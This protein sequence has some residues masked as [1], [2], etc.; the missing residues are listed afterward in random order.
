VAVL[1]AALGGAAWYFGP[2]AADDPPGAQPAAARA[3]AWRSHPGLVE[4]KAP[5]PAD[6]NVPADPARRV[7][8][9]VLDEAGAPVPGADVQVFT[10]AQSAGPFFRCPAESVA[11][12]LFDAPC[13]EAGAALFA[14]VNESDSVEPVPLFAVRSGE[15]GEFAFDPPAEP[16]D[17]YVQLG[18]RY[19]TLTDLEATPE[20]GADSSADAGAGAGEQDPALDPGQPVQVER[21]RLELQL[22]E[23]PAVGGRVYSG[24]EAVPGADVLAVQQRPLRIWRT[25]ANAAGEFSFGRL[26][27]GPSLG[28]AAVAPGYLPLLQA[29]PTDE[30][31]ALELQR[32]GVVSGIVRSRGAPAAGARVSLDHGSQSAVADAEGRFSFPAVSCEICEVIGALGDRWAREEVGLDEHRKASLELDLQPVGE[33]QVHLVDRDTGAPLEGTLSCNCPASPEAP[34]TGLFVLPHAARGPLELVAQAEGHVPLR[35]TVE[36]G[37]GS[38]EV[39][40]ALDP[41]QRVEGRVLGPDGAPL[42]GALVSAFVDSE[43]GEETVATDEE[44]RF[45]LHGLGAGRHVVAATHPLH[46]REEV[47]VSL[48]AAGPLLLRLRLAARLLAEVVDPDGAPVPG[49][50]VFARLPQPNRMRSSIADEQ[51]RA[52]LS[53]LAPGSYLVSAAAGGWAGSEQVSVL[54]GAGESQVRLTLRR[55]LSIAGRVVDDAGAPVGRAEIYAVPQ[56]PAS[57]PL[58]ASATCDESGHFTL[59]GLEDAPYVLTPRREMDEGASSTVR[60]GAEAV[61]LRIDRPGEV[62]GRVTL[63]GQPLTT[64][65][66]VEGAPF[67]TEDGSFQLGLSPGEH[68]LTVAGSFAPRTFPVTV[69]AG[70]QVDVGEIAVGRGGVIEG[71]ALSPDG[72][73]AVGLDIVLTSG[74]SEERCPADH[75]GRFRFTDL[76]EGPYQLSAAGAQGFV[77]PVSVHLVEGQTLPTQLQAEAAGRL[78]GSV[79]DAAGSLVRF[80]R[81]ELRGPAEDTILMTVCDRRGEFAFDGLAPGPYRVIASGPASGLS[82]ERT[83]DVRGRGE[84]RAELRLPTLVAAETDLLEG[85]L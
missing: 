59:S 69:K 80:A 13:P 56:S 9:V 44:G 63:A 11:M 73:P 47:T 21:E 29:L 18:T 46:L 38:N 25:S 82:A 23:G 7:R 66:Y 55:G 54:A 85:E 14:L 77:R 4:A 41:E 27:G 19:A 26:P 76:A 8:G 60:P 22:S 50:S 16:F 39:V 33:L 74:G 79:T 48:P 49:A 67:E 81:V 51:G 12:P 15:K 62:V 28:A 35:K 5:R 31:A 6:P 70:Q 17:L 61:V 32:P 53:P 84:T 10:S 75:D 83:L 36:V 20:S 2:D 40:L 57:S 71:V 45:Q 78:A 68:E 1:A 58:P 37:P 52:D 65:F 72:A 3:A 30:P 24:E 64:F 42:S 34:A 43:V